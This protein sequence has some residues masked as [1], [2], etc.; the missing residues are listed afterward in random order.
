MTFR[1]TKGAGTLQESMVWPASL[2]PLEA[3]HP[4]GRGALLEES[5]KIGIAPCKHAACSREA[6][7]TCITGRGRASPRPVGIKLKLPGWGW[8]PSRGAISSTPLTASKNT[9]AD[10][11]LRSPAPPISPAGQD[12]MCDCRGMPSANQSSAGRH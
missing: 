1:C 12:S 7:K 2:S 8:N 3:C 4:L 5:L 6:S 10:P 9:D 11:A